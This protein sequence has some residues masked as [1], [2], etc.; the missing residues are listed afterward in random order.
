MSV[1]HSQM[2]GNGNGNRSQSQ[3]SRA[4]LTPS[5][6]RGHNAGQAQSQMGMI[7]EEHQSVASNSMHVSNGLDVVFWGTDITV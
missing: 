6:N 1:V 7:Q 2:G 3:R 4:Y 5:H